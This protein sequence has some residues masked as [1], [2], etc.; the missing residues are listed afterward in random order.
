LYTSTIVSNH[1][2]SDPVPSFSC[3]DIW[4]VRQTT[5][6]VYATHVTTSTYQ[7]VVDAVDYKYNVIVI[8]RY[9]ENGWVNTDVL[10][11]TVCLITEIYQE[12]SFSFHGSCMYN[13]SS[14]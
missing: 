7:L 13:H 5:S 4:N 2:N 14:K 10:Y 11:P 12:E 1:V 9:Q 6:G 8:W 3:L